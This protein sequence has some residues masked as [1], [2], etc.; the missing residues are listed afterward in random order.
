VGNPGAYFAGLRKWG[1]TVVAEDAYPDHHAY[2]EAELERLSARARQA[3]AVALLTTEKDAV[4]FPPYWESE[5]PILA[6][7]IQAEIAEA[8]EFEQLL[9]ECLEAA[10]TRL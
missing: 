6:C 7:A 1:F 9:E 3:G 10:P 4:N 8:E 2:T 5:F